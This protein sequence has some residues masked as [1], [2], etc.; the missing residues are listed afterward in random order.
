MGSKREDRHLR[1]VPV[2]EQIAESVIREALQPG[3]PLELLAYARSH[4]M[5][6]DSDKVHPALA[7]EMGRTGRTIAWPP[8]RNQRCWCGSGRKYKQRCLRK[9]WPA[10][11]CRYPGVVMKP[12]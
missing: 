4:D 11:R 1:A 2:P 10:T 8:E 6:P 3:H 5:E 9:G 12:A 7:A